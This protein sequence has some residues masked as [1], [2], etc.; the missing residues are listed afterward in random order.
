MG[1]VTER[2]NDKRTKVTKWNKNVIFFEKGV[3]IWKTL[4]YTVAMNIGKG[5]WKNEKNYNYCLLVYDGFNHGSIPAEY[6]PGVIA[7]SIYHEGY[8]TVN[9]LD[10]DNDNI[11]FK[12]SICSYYF[13][14]KE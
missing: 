2:L 4:C 9:V 6:R 14:A 12:N 1:K 8:K 11:K 5:A 7:F 13:P 3:T 10:F